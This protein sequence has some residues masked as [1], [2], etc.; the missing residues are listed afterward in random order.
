MAPGVF[1]NTQFCLCSVMCLCVSV[2]ELL[3]QYVCVFAGQCVCTVGG[4][5][6]AY[7]VCVWPGCVCIFLLLMLGCEKYA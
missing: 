7:S 1:V 6:S 4:F 5:D 3:C 2:L